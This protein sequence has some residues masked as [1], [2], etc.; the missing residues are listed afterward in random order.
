MTDSASAGVE[1]GHVDANGTSL[2]YERRGS[3]PSVLFIQG[4]TG[5]AGWFEDIAWRLADEFTVVTYDRRGNS[6]SRGARR[7]STTMDEQADDAAAVL[8]GL[9]VAP[10]AAFGTSGGGVILLNLLLRH[11]DLLRGAIVHEPALFSVLPNAAATM[12]EQRARVQAA[13]AQGGPAAGLE[14]FVRNVAGDANFEA[15]SDELRQR[16]VANGEHFFGGELDA[17]VSYVPDAEALRAS[18]LPL[19]VALGEETEPQDPATVA[20]C[21][22]LADTAGAELVRVP[23][24]HVGYFDRAAETADALRPILRRF[25]PATATSAG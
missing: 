13:I 15:L 12:N 11:P 24:A 10:A 17:F 25:A 18:R 2:Y 14:R 1:A 23:G 3:R 8:Q 22:W 16:I 4:A 5:D 7:S 20:I 6:R 19:V 21:E 9:D